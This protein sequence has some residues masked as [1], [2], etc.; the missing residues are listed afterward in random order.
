MATDLRSHCLPR[1]HSANSPP[2]PDRGRK[3]HAT[4]VV[5][6]YDSTVPMTVTYS[7]VYCDPGLLRERLARMERAAFVALCDMGEE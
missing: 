1:A 3:R 6:D 7:I 2:W 4:V 5:S